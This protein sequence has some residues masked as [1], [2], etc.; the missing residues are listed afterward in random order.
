M[1]NFEATKERRDGQTSNG[2]IWVS[3]IL[4]KMLVPSKSR[5]RSGSKNDMKLDGCVI[6][7]KSSDIMQRMLIFRRTKSKFSHRKKSS[8][9]LSGSEYLGF[10]EEFS[11]G[12]KRGE[13]FSSRP[14]QK[15][16]W[17]Q[18]IIEEPPFSTRARIFS[19]RPWWRQFDL[20]S[21]R[22]VVFLKIGLAET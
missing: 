10:P 12:L 11:G 17:K 3:F 15:S 22:N 9:I 20:Y 16:Q 2:P 14:E 7:G 13:G 5:F 21:R 6:T 19:P 18:R 8:S 1:V 4:Q